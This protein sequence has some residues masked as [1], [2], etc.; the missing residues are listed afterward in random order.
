[1]Q[2]L[3]YF[4]CF[5]YNIVA[6]TKTTLAE[7]NVIGSSESDPFLVAMKPKSLLCFPLVSQKNLQAVLYV[8]SYTVDAFRKEE[9]AVLKV[10]A[11]QA[12]VSLEKLAIYQELDLTNK[13]LIASNKRVE[14]QSQH[15]ADEVL[16]RTAELHEKIVELNIAKN[17]AELAKEVAEKAQNEAEEAKDSAEHAN[18]LKGT[19]LATMS[20]EIRTPFNAVSRR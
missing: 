11:V 20:H 12:A 6:L 18:R 1:M 14:E 10:L 3:R 16:A 15:L 7:I 13:A 9:L 5:I 17:E 8:H 4:R 2:L 19:F